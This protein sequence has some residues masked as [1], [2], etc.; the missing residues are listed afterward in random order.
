MVDDL[1][2]SRDGGS[3]VPLTLIA[4]LPSHSHYTPPD[5]RLRQFEA[6]RSVIVLCCASF[7][8]PARTGYPRS[9]SLSQH[10]L[11]CSLAELLSQIVMSGK[12]TLRPCGC[13]CNTSAKDHSAF[14]WFESPYFPL[15]C[16]K[17]VLRD[18][19]SSKTFTA[20]F[21]LEK[22]LGIP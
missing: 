17:C 4:A 14:K 12:H 21:C 5:G 15:K 3:I 11:G 19:K 13:G 16:L 22:T 20:H 7:V 10:T 2:D 9:L 6:L 1:S 18:N 8:H